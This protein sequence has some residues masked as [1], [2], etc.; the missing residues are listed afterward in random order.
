LLIPN[1]SVAG[2]INQERTQWWENIV[3][4][5]PPIKS[6]EEE[7]TRNQQPFFSDQEDWNNE[8]RGTA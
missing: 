3:S 7:N 2:N 4:N 5:Q 1:S 8:S 6:I